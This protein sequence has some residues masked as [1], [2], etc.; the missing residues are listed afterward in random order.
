[1]QLTKIDKEVKNEDYRGAKIIVTLIKAENPFYDCLVKH[2]II[3]LPVF[4]GTSPDTLVKQAKALI[5]FSE[6]N[7]A[8]IEEEIEQITEQKVY[9]SWQKQQ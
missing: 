4:T 2:T 9:Q 5:D 7:R 1:M 3:R 8:G 6:K